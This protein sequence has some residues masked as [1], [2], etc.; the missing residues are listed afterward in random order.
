MSAHARKR[1]KEESI[2]YRWLR[3]LISAP[4]ATPAPV[5]AAPAPASAPAPDVPVTPVAAPAAPVPAPDGG[6][7]RPAGPPVP[8]ELR[9]RVG[10]LWNAWLF[11]R[12]D[13]GGL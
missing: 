3:R 4:S 8:F 10:G 5:D 12:A 7:A 13:E 1:N 6:P 11:E 2:M 9:D